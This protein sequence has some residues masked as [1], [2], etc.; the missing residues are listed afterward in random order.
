MAGLSA[1][2]ADPRTFGVDIDRFILTP[3]EREEGSWDLI[4]TA[5]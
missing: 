1:L 5:L 2:A 4:E 3:F